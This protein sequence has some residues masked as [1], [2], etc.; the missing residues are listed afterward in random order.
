MAINEKIALLYFS[1]NA[2]AEGR[3]KAWFSGNSA[4]KNSALASS[5][6]H[7]SSRVLQQTGFPLF[8]YHEGNQKGKTFG[9]RIANAHEEVF[10]LG[11]E[12]I[13]TVGND[14]PE[15]GNTNWH[16]VGS[17]LA[18]GKCVIGP[19]LRGGA[20]L[21]GITKDAFEK[22]QFQNLPWQT[23]QL[24][25][26]LFQ[27]CHLQEETPFLLETLRDINSW[28]DLK[29]VLKSSLITTSFKR[30]ILWL[31]SLKQ[32]LFIYRFAFIPASPLLTN[33]PFRA[34]PFHLHF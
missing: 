3:A 18:S 12:A 10:S 25:D 17:Q 19:S 6:I 28:H 1:R 8:H 24:F 31:F 21:I 32:S 20:Y 26:A 4:K 9:E 27:F 15:I 30:L 2:A 22:E 23:S 13:I 5:L 14:S 34:P 16:E 29:K 7:Q 11:Y 33:S